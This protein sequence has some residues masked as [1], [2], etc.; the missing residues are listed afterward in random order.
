MRP[1]GDWSMLMALSMLFEALDLL[2]PA[3]QLPRPV[4]LGVRAPWRG[5]PRTRV[6]LPLPDTPVTAMNRPERELDI[7]VLAGCSRRRPA[8]RSTAAVPA[9]PRRRHRDRPAAGQ[10][11]A[12]DRGRSAR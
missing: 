5:S 1:I 3:R 2:V 6:D 4:Q 11:V 10:V 9:A 7:E 12:G 8:P